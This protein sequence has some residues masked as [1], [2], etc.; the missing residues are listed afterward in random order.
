MRSIHDFIIFQPKAY[1]DSFTTEGGVKLFLDRS[2]SKDKLANTLV[3]VVSVPVRASTHSTSSGTGAAEIKEGDE[4]IV[5]RTIFL[6]TNY[7]KTGEQTSPYMADRE[8]GY[9]KVPKSMVLLYR[10]STASTPST[11]SGTGASAGS[12]TDKWKAF[13]NNLI[14]EF[15]TKEEE[16]KQGLIITGFSKETV[17]GI[18][19]VRYVNSELES[20]GVC[21]GDTIHIPAN[22]GVPFFIDGKNLFWIKNH[23]VLAKQ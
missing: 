14:V 23:E 17:K 20:Q 6:G 16:T 3:K 11:S 18:A 2:F 10:P 1:T 22:S 5:D 7:E 13:D 9:Y 12:V 19:I 8:R 21:V 4:V 15:I